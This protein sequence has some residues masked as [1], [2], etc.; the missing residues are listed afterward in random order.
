MST[1]HSVKGKSGQLNL[2]MHKYLHAVNQRNQ[3]NLTQL[4]ISN[5]FLWCFVIFR[6]CSVR[7]PL[8]YRLRQAF[9]GADYGREYLTLRRHELV[10]FEFTSS[11]VKEPIRDAFAPNRSN[12]LIW[13]QG[14]PSRTLPDRFVSS[15]H[16]FFDFPWFIG[17]F[18]GNLGNLCWHL[19]W[20]TL[21]CIDSP[22][23]SSTSRSDGCFSFFDMS[24]SNCVL[25]ENAGVRSRRIAISEL[26]R[27]CPT[28]RKL[29]EVINRAS[30]CH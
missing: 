10:Q 30:S 2:F 15:R 9:D 13:T 19:F 12:E 27:Y 1:L 8:W 28:M 5:N 26:L 11:D 21:P 18:W 3:S 20:N 25:L 14:P 6:I 17:V 24:D 29:M 4:C 7:G 23:A 16:G 22:L